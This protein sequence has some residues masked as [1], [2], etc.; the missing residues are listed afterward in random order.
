MFG[1]GKSNNGN[2]YPSVDD[3]IT[4]AERGWAKLRREHAA[5]VNATQVNGKAEAPAWVTCR[6]NAR[7]NS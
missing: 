7:V 1:K 3:Q 5:L 2:S 4:A 6:N